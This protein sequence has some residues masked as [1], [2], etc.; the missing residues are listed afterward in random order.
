M[1]HKTSSMDKL[2]Q[3]LSSR[4]GSDLENRN[5]IASASDRVS[6]NEKVS[7]LLS[8]EMTKCA[9][10][11]M[12]CASGFPCGAPKARHLRRLVRAC[13]ESPQWRGQANVA[14]TLACLGRVNAL[15]SG[16]V[17]LKMTAVVHALMQFG[18]AE[19]LPATYAWRDHLTIVFE[20]YASDDGDLARERR[21]MSKEYKAR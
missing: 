19:T 7:A 17:A 14:E 8:R 12:K 10:S 9:Y 18:S 5:A 1:S 20:A 16:V 13:W 6:V 3:S 11:A 2:D 21:H 4:G 15:C